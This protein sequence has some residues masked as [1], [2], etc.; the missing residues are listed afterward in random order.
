MKKC[1]REVDEIGYVR[2]QTF[3]LLL[4]AAFLIALFRGA[5]RCRTL[6]GKIFRVSGLSGDGIGMKS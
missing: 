6:S 5:F 1:E 4:L 3:F 2:A